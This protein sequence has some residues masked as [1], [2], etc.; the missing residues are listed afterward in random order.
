MDGGTHEQGCR[1]WMAMTA[2]PLATLSEKL[3][4]PYTKAPLCWGDTGR[5]SASQA[6]ALVPSPNPDRLSRAGA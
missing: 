6:S 1:L 4:A 3:M 2:S 5:G